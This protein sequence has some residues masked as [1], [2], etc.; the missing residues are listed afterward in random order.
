ALAREQ[1]VSDVEAPHRGEMR[2]GGSLGDRGRDRGAFVSTLLDGMENLASPFSCLRTRLVSPP[3]VCVEVPA[4]IGEPLSRGRV[5]GQTAAANHFSDAGLGIDAGQVDQRG[6]DIGDLNAGVVE[7]VLNLDGVSEKAQGAHEN[8]SENS[9]SEMA[10]MGRLVRIDIGVLDDDLALAAREFGR[11]LEQRRDEG[12]ALKREVDVAASFDAHRGDARR[13]AYLL[14]KLSGDR[15]R[16]P[17]KRLGEVEGHGARE[18]AHRDLGRPLEIDSFGR[19]A[20]D[21][22]H[23]IT[24]ASSEIAS[25]RVEG[26]A[27]GGA[28]ISGARAAGGSP[29]S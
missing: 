26:V 28:S 13:K 20:A 23:G 10:D 2:G 15:P 5:T 17:A 22:P 16:G 14:R 7:V 8:V 1:V 3:D 21:L 11:C 24:Q 27:H 29:R 6:D 12:A 19:V 25:N 9:I 4:E 18:V